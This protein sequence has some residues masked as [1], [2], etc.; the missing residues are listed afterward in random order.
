MTATDFFRYLLVHE[1]SSD[2]ALQ[3]IEVY[4]SRAYMQQQLPVE[5]QARS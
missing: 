1:P 2:L 3:L 4:G 5:G